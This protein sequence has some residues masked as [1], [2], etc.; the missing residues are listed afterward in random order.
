M[1]T[2]EFVS[3]QNVKIEYELASTAQRFLAAFIDIA[4]F[5]IYF[6]T[7][8]G[9]LG[10]NTVLISTKGSDL[11]LLLIIIKIPFIFYHPICEYFTNGQSLGKY[12]IGIRVVTVQGE[13]I[14]LKEIFTRWIFKGEFLWISLDF[15]ILCWLGIGILGIFFSS[16]SERNQRIGDLMAGSVVIKNKPSIKYSISDVLAIKNQTDYV[17]T[18]PAVVKLTDEDML[19]IKTTIQ[20]V[21]KYQTPQVKDFAIQLADESARLIGLSETPAKRLDFLQTLLQDYVVLT[22]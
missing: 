21:R 17:P 12:L 14:G 18:Y 1:K 15:L 11:L 10:Y 3:A 6:M 13:R 2:I 19:L 8:T 9:I 20:R 7:L 4:M 22:R 16:I 5:T